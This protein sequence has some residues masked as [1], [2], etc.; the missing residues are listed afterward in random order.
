[1]AF[2]S[3]LMFFIIILDDAAGHISTRGEELYWLARRD[4]D[5]VGPKAFCEVTR[6]PQPGWMSNRLEARPP[7]SRP[8]ATPR[9]LG[10]GAFRTLM[11]V[12]GGALGK[13]PAG[14]TVES[15]A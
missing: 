15:L 10:S 4:A 9:S 3:G 11:R 5:D 2:S 14:A 13:W 6:D 7:L 1:M 12:V 8:I